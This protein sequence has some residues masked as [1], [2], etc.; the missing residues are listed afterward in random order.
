MNLGVVLLPLGNPGG[1]CGREKPHILPVAEL[2]TQ[3][4]FFDDSVF[5]RGWFGLLVWPGLAVCPIASVYMHSNIITV[6][7]SS[8][9]GLYTQ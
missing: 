5:E 3:S 7:L 9:S 4:S 2:S 6:E 1:T 8:L